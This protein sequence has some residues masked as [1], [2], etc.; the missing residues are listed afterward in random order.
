MNIIADSTSGSDIILPVV[1]IPPRRSG[2]R[3]RLQIALLFLDVCVVTV[4]MGLV[5]FLWSDNHLGRHCLLIIAAF[6]PCYA[7]TSANCGALAS[8]ILARRRKSVALGMRAVLLACACVILGAFFLKGGDELSRITLLV[9]GLLGCVFVGIARTV[10]QTW[11]LR[12]FGAD[13]YCE[14]L[15]MD[16]CDLESRP[17][18]F[19]ID[20]S[21]LDL[22]GD[23]SHP[24]TLHRIGGILSSADRVVIACRPDRRRAWSMVLK[25]AHVQAEIVC[26]EISALGPLGAGWFAESATIVVATGPF[27]LRQRFLKRG[28]DFALACG[29]LAI[30]FPL[31]VLVGLAIKLDSPGS[32]LFVQNRVGRSN[33]LFGIYKF[34]SMRSDLSDRSGTRSTSRDDDRIT[35]VG[36][37]I[38]ATSI[39]ELPQILNI[40]K[41][42]MSFVGPRPHAL[43][44]LAG[45]RLFWEVDERYSHRHACKP[46]LTGLAQVRG[47]RG[48]THNQIDLVNRLQADLEYHAGWTIWRD[49]SIL[50]ATLRVVVHR[51]AY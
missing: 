41:G 19:R 29:A 32:I 45:D 27:N 8:A 5:G 26:P 20:A 23:L 37:F 46:G 10:F 39:D 11:S 42:Q 40:L 21:T 50:F 15:V 3:L 31:F 30:L 48:A 36:R 28:L 18:V 6:L 34:R 24:M 1:A 51:N 47:F 14:I 22:L 17:G 49:I 4:A 16:D 12:R 44:S 9:G 7:I 33:R 2:L 35:R 13:L 25:G 43:G 38:R